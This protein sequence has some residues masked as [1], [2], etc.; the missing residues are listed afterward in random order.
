[1]LIADTLELLSVAPTL[2]FFGSSPQEMMIVG[3]VA[4]LLYA[5]RLPIPREF[6][7]GLRQ[8]W[9]EKTRQAYVRWPPVE[10]MT[11]LGLLLAGLKIL[12]VLMH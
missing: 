5:D 3:I 8:T 7:D 11:N 2:A 12:R 1:M 9:R 6:L 4:L 10:F